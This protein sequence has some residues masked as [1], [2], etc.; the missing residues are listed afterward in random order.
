VHR[1]TRPNGPVPPNTHVTVLDPDVTALTHKVAPR[2]TASTPDW[3]CSTSSWM[4][5]SINHRA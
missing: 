2:S 4:K 3:S 5:T 1:P